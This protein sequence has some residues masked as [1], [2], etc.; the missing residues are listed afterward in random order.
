VDKENLPSIL[1][2]GHYLPLTQGQK[3]PHPG[4]ELQAN[5]SIKY[6]LQSPGWYAG[7]EA[8]TFHS[9]NLPYTKQASL[10]GNQPQCCFEV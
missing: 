5:Y 2:L 7:S 3:R 8:A 9:N 6:R 1:K 4:R 10:K